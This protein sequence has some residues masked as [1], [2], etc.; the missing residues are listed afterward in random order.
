[1]SKAATALSIT[2]NRLKAI[3]QNP[4]IYQHAKIQFTTKLKVDG[5]PVRGKTYF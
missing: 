2:K 1:L 4:L 3:A 5:L